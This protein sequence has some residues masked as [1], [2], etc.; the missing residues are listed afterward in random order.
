MSDEKVYEIENMDELR[1]IIKE[2]PEGMMLEIS[3]AKEEAADEI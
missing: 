3:V 2:L 1:D